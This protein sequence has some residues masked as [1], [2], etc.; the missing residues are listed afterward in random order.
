MKKKTHRVNFT[1]QPVAPVY[2]G[3][4][5]VQ[6]ELERSSLTTIPVSRRCKNGRKGS[7]VMTH[8]YEQG[9]NFKC[10]TREDARALYL[11][12]KDSEGVAAFHQTHKDLQYDMD[13][14]KAAEVEYAAQQF[15]KHEIVKLAF[16]VGQSGENN[17]ALWKIDGCGGAGSGKGMGPFVIAYACIVHNPLADVDDHYP[18]ASLWSAIL[19]VDCSIF[20]NDIH[21][22]GL[23]YQDAAVSA[24]ADPDD[25]RDDKEDNDDDEKEDDNNSRDTKTKITKSKGL[26]SS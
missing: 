16:T 13:A 11:A 1:P 3:K 4:D 12:N 24:A 6:T 26:Q 20:E 5:E 7:I 15:I 8:F 21:K 19:P 23:H 18:N 10:M 2:I 17:R 9:H 25:D 14:G 22:D